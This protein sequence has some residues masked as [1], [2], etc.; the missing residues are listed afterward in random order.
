M[1]RCRTFLFVLI[2]LPA[3]VACSGGDGERSP[4]ESR[5]TVGELCQSLLRFVETE[6]SADGVEVVPNGDTARD[7][8][9]RG[10][11][12]IHGTSEA[13]ARKR[14]AT[15][16]LGIWKDWDPAQIELVEGVEPAVVVEREYGQVTLTAGV[17]EWVGSLTL[18]ADGLRTPAGPA[19]LGQP[20]DRRYAEFLLGLVREYGQWN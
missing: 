9:R 13:G 15:V 4:A 17:D 8:G 12:E 20:A 10:T 11:C 2:I 1:K 7:L 6:F 19:D 18:V 14:A 16:T 3:L 5:R